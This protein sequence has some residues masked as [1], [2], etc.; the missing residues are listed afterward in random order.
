MSCL[1]LMSAPSPEETVSRSTSAPVAL[2]LAGRF[3]TAH[4]WTTCTS[5]V[6]LA[7][8]RHPDCAVC[9]ALMTKFSYFGLAPPPANMKPV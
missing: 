9:Q 6:D 4:R 7:V 2:P 3:E 8:W 1:K 5:R